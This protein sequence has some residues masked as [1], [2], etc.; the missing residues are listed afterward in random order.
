ME[1]IM[2]SKEYKDWRNF[3]IRVKNARNSIGMTTEQLAEKSNRS[4]NYIFRVEAG[5]SCSIHTL[6]QL[7]KALNKSSDYLLFGED[8]KTEIIN[9]S[10]REI[11]DNI[12]NQC[13]EN[14]LKIIKDVLIAICPNFDELKK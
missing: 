6:Y 4:E 11:I 3:G 7:S 14:Q 13:D 12:L 5:Q 8:M 9:Y 10:D 1:A 2:E